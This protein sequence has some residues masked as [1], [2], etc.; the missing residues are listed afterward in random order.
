MKKKLMTLSL[1]LAA[2]IALPS[3]MNA[4]EAKA[5]QTENTECTNPVCTKDQKEC[6]KGDKRQKRDRKDFKKDRRHD[7]K[8]GFMDKRQP[9]MRKA[10]EQT[11]FEGITLTS[12]QQQQFTA[13]KEKRNAEHKARNAEMKKQE[14]AKREARAAEMKARREAYDKEVEKILTPEQYKQYQ[15]NKEKMVKERSQKAV[16]DGQRAKAKCQKANIECQNA[17]VEE[18]ATK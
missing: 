9:R 2:V 5:V 18:Q 8:K 17:I 4:Q 6:N 1:A 15:A 16:V 13:L 11:L 10:G 7:F 12:D 14:A 3:A